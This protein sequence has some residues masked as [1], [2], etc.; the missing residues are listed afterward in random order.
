MDKMV[1]LG[2]QKAWVVCT[3][4]RKSGGKVQLVSALSMKRA[5]RWNGSQIYA[6]VV[7]EVQED[8]VGMPVPPELT[9]LLGNFADIIPDE[10]PKVL[11]PR[12]IVDHRIELEP[13][14]QPPTRAP[15]RLSGPELEELKQ[16]LT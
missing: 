11:P 12:H 14:L 7:G 9:D 5:T 3:T 13:G 2:E 4:A 16:Q 8:G 6:T 15:Y 1:I 10:L